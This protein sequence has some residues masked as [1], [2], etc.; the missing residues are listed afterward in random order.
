MR[1][2]VEASGLSRLE[3]AEL[4]GCGSSQIFK[5]QKE[6]LPPRMNQAVKA[7]ILK[8]AAQAG[9]TPTAVDK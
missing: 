9:V 1:A 6:G 4:V 2:V 7:H 3:F 8:M 5:Y